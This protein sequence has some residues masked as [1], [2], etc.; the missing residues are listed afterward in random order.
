MLNACEFRLAVG[1]AQPGSTKDAQ[2][3]WLKA[4]LAGTAAAALAAALAPSTAMAQ[5]AAAA[6]K[7]ASEIEAV[8]VTARRREETAQSV[9][10]TV[11]ILGS[12]ELARAGIQDLHAIAQNVPGFNVMSMARKDTTI[13]QLRGQR[14]FDVR[15]TQDAPVAIYFN[16]VVM[17][18]QT[19]SNMGIYDLQSVQVLK[20]PQG[21]LFGRNTTGGAVLYTPVKPGDTHQGNVTAGYGRF[22]RMHLEGGVTMPINDQASMRIS[23]RIVRQDGIG[24]IVSGALRG[25]DLGDEKSENVRVSLVLGAHTRLENY[26]IGYYDHYR[27]HG[28]AMHPV[29]LTGASLLYNGGPPFGLPDIQQAVASNLGNYYDT[30]SEVRSFVNTKAFGLN[31]TTTFDLGSSRFGDLKI[32]NILAYRGVRSDGLID[33]DGTPVGLLTSPQN[34]KNSDQFSEE[35]QLQG[36][37][38]TAQ[39][40]V[41]GYYYRLNGDDP[42]ENVIALQFLNP[43]NPFSTSGKVRNTSYS[44]YGEVTTN[45]SFL[46]DSDALRKLSLTL[47]ARES[48]DKRYMFVY[49]RLRIGTPNVVSAIPAALQNVPDGRTELKS[50]SAFTYNATLD[51][52]FDSG[53]MIFISQKRGYRSGGFNIGATNVLAQFAPFQPEK[54]D[55]TEAGIKTETRFGDGMMLRANLT[56]F[57]SKYKGIQRNVSEFNGNTVTTF[58]L[59]A[60]NGSVKGAEADVLFRPTPFLDLSA[61]GSYTK[62]EYDNFRDAVA[63]YTANRFAWTPK[64]TASVTANLHF[65]VGDDGA[66][67]SIQANYY[68]QSKIFLDERTQA[69][70]TTLAGAPA[71]PAAWYPYL[72]QGGY[73]LTNF[74]VSL[75]DFGR[76]GLTLSTYLKN[77]FDKRYVTGGV[78]AA[79]SLGFISRIYGDP[80]T[81]GV[82]ASYRF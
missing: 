72:S 60:G 3:P 69:T 51:Y 68:Y 5:P 62:A 13:L 6:A 74:R 77:A 18:P 10:L 75:E 78:V 61:F 35:L 38:D 76:K 31:N 81:W 33:Y 59:N 37:N 42:T 8:V 50:F 26:T 45:L 32:K 28:P 16:D 41:G 49:S 47:G 2:R 40:V 36:S 67:L 58:I 12:A 79:G 15:P 21:T 64:W 65:P 4:L 20:G 63:N 25:Y 48:W 39:W 80:R 14:S 23:G 54:I 1:H 30:N 57:Y 53:N 22:N 46:G 7:A 17:T 52:K 82:D 71:Y 24:E 55:Q 29:Y 11:S 27:S 43:G 73:G 9:P 34:G 19:G 66:T 44:L 70:A 56:G